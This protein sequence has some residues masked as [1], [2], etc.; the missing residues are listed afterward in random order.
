M[1]KPFQLRPP[2]KQ[3]TL[4]APQ[5]QIHPALIIEKFDIEGHMGHIRLKL[6]HDLGQEIQAG[7][8][9]MHTFNVALYREFMLCP[10]STAVFRAVRIHRS[11]AK[12]RAPAGLDPH[13]SPRQKFESRSRFS[14]NEFDR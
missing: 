5:K 3:D 6:L 10:C 9:G 12:N 8:H 14:S 1:G 7:A 4:L 13:T 11:F 2:G